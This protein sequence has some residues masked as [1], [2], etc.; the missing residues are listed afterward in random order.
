MKKAALLILCLGLL[1]WP[2]VIWGWVMPVTA[3]PLLTTTP[4]LTPTVTPTTLPTF[5]ATAEVSTSDTQLVVGEVISVTTSLTI[6]PGCSFPLMELALTQLGEDAPI[7]AP[8]SVILGPPI[9][10]PQTITLTAV[11][12][13]TITFRSALFGERYCGDYWNWWW[14]DDISEPVTVL[15]NSS[16]EL[17]D[18]IIS[19]IT[20]NPGTPQC[21]THP[22]DLGARVWVQ[23]VGDAPAGPFV[24][25]VN[26]GPQQTVS[27]LAAGEETSLVFGGV[28]GSVTAVADAT[29]LIV[30]SNEANNSF[31]TILPIPTL[32]PPCTPTPTPAH[33]QFLPVTIR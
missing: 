27:G 24:V 1:V 26:G 32:P 10:M 33:R 23:N 8:E 31:T 13:G 2:L 4:T 11:T 16:G 7:F 14:A 25:E 21:D 6:A 3:V 5:W 20:Y 28:L 15:S 19:N 9:P 22:P 30:E 17:P 12:T 18:L 29:N